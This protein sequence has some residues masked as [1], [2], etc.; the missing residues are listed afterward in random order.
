MAKEW[1]ITNRHEKIESL[2]RLLREARGQCIHVCKMIILPMA[3]QEFCLSPNSNA[4]KGGLIGLAG[5]AIALEQGRLV[6]FVNI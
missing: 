4:R 6:V 3:M 5:M 2:I 1:L